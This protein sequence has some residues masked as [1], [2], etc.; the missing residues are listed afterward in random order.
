MKK[1]RNDSMN[2]I[3]GAKTKT[4]GKSCQRYPRKNR[5]CRLHGGLSTGPKTFEGINRIKKANLKH[6]KYTKEAYL[7]SKVFKEFI[8]D[9]KEFLNK[10]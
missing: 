8:M 7:A 10:F 9:C 5:R 6:G 4:T 3:C 1:Q 2:P